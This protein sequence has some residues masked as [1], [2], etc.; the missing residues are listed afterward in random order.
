MG[1]LWG[2]AWAAARMSAKASSSDEEKK[3]L[4]Y[5]RC[6]ILA[7]PGTPTVRLV[8]SQAAPMATL[9]PP[10]LAEAATRASAP[11]TRPQAPTVAEAASRCHHVYTLARQ[12]SASASAAPASAPAVHTVGVLSALSGCREP[13]KA[14][15]SAYAGS[16]G[17]RGAWSRSYSHTLR[18]RDACEEFE[19]GQQWKQWAHCM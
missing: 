13:N 5:T 16:S 6:R 10:G 1:S 11:P 18:A 15:A 14:P 19:A 3:D 8:A 7:E 9:E 2:S 12:R 17:P 4:E